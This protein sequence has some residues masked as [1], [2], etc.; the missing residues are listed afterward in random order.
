M[1]D[2]NLKTR[3]YNQMKPLKNK[4]YSNETELFKYLWKVNEKEV[5]HTIKLIKLSRS[6]TCLRRSGLCNLC[7]KANVEI[8]LSQARPS[9]QLNRHYEVLTC[10]HAS[11]P[12]SIAPTSEHMNTK[13]NCHPY[14]SEDHRRCCYCC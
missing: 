2:N 8:L 6:S 12:T 3:Y 9:W 4:R 13:P 14:L 5:E 1:T 7:L 10:R 11:P